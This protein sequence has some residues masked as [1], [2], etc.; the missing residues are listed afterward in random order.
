MSLPSQI[1][2]RGM[3]SSD[4]VTA[5]IN[6]E[7]AKLEHLFP[8]LMSC[9]VVVEAPHRHHHKGNLF[10]VSIDVAVPHAEIVANRDAGR[11]HAHEDVYVAIRDAFLAVS[12]KLQDRS[13][14]HSGGAKRHA[15]N[16]R[17]VE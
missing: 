3:S 2:F 6:A 13:S 16:S 9:R 14:R 15:A 12:R 4:A 8:Q 10:S 11:D 5:R 17:P 7:I 1:T